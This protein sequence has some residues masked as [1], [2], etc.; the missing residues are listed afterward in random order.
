[1]SCLDWLED[2]LNSP[3]TYFSRIS[4]IQ[5]WLVTLTCWQ[6]CHDHWQAESCRAHSGASSL[7]ILQPAEQQDLSTEELIRLSSS[8]KC[9]FHYSVISTA[10]TTLELLSCLP[11]ELRS[12]LRPLRSQP[13]PLLGPQHCWLFCS[14]LKNQRFGYLEVICF[15]LETFNHR[16]F[17]QLPP[18]QTDAFTANDPHVPQSP[19]SPEPLL[20]AHSE[21]GNLCWVYLVNPAPCAW[22]QSSMPSRRI[23]HLWCL[24]NSRDVM[25]SFWISSLVMVYLHTTTERGSV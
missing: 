19:L 25:T 13:M 17:L 6:W 14:S 2:G 9:T 18:W 22:K 11:L 20:D 4:L 15:H 24:V 1:M 16:G 12:C 7:S 21:F 8:W 10:E 23:L 3:E 5:L